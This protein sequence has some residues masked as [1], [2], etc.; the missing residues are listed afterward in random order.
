M[1]AESVG[2]VGAVGDDVE[3]EGGGDGADSEGVSALI[4][5][6]QRWGRWKCDFLGW[7]M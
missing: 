6:G 5:M 2:V 7:G 3:V 1:V 4:V